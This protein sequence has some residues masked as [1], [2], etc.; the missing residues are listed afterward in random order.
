MMESLLQPASVNQKDVSK[1]LK[2]IKEDQKMHHDSY[3]NS[4]LKAL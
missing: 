1:Y 2:K 3:A 4:E